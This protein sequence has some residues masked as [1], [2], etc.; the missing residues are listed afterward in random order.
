MQGSTNEAN[1]RLGIGTQP[2]GPNRK[3]VGPRPTCYAA[4][5]GL[6]GAGRAV[7]SFRGEP[8]AGTWVPDLDGTEHRLLGG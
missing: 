5:L 1:R 8:L 3:A 2:F 4:P 7:V 6:N